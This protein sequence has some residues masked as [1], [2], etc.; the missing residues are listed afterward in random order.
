MLV[1]AFEPLPVGHQGPSEQPSEVPL[2]FQY[3]AF[4]TTA[5]TDESLPPSLTI[6]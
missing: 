2:S 4:L 3:D 1:P 6:L 5:Q